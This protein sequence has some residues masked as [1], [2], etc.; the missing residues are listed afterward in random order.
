MLVSEYR[1][2]GLF[3]PLQMISTDDRFWLKHVRALPT[4]NMRPFKWAPQFIFRAF[5]E[6]A[7]QND[8]ISFM[9]L[10]ESSLPNKFVFGTRKTW[11]REH[12]KTSQNGQKACWRGSVSIKC[13]FCAGQL[14][15]KLQLLLPV[16]L[17]PA[18]ASIINLIISYVQAF[19]VPPWTGTLTQEQNFS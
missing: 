4:M 7:S 5:F 11:T 15:R 2:S 18:F 9:Q 8:H 16:H 14:L 6:P 1:L 12:V 13:C 19:R 10:K 3:P 17:Q